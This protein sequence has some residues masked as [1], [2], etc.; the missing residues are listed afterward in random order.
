M[1]FGETHRYVQISAAG[2]LLA[3]GYHETTSAQV[4]RLRRA[5]ADDV[6]GPALERAVA[7]VRR[8]G[9]EISGDQLTR[10]P[11]GYPK[12]HPR[13]DLLRYKTLFATRQLGCPDWLATAA[14]RSEITKQLR[15]L[16]PV[17]DWLDT[18]VAA[19]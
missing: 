5:V 19:G 8:A 3:G 16:Q 2:L 18:H 4:E 9:F 14:A 1:W 10:V 7:R 12:D 17:V 13:A 15:A 6:A 11:G